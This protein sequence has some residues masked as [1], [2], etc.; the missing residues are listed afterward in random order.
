MASRCSLLLLKKLHRTTAIRIIRGYRTVSYASASVLEAS[1]PFELHA[2]ALR[3]VYQ[4]LRS[5]SMVMDGA[6]IPFNAKTRR[7][8]WQRAQKCSGSNSEEVSGHTS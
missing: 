7:E 6:V 1:P 4:N 5:L 3:Q 8:E 2:L